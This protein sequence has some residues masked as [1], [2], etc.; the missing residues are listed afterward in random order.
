MPETPSP[1]S[2]S[3]VTGSNVVDYLMRY[4][5][6]ELTFTEELDLFQYLVDTGMAYTLQGHYGRAANRLI[7]VGLVHPRRLP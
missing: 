4:E 5:S 1:T 2:P 3:P 6:D 7:D